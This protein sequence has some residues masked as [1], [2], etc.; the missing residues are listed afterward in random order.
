LLLPTR[1][2]PL[3]LLVLYRSAGFGDFLETVAGAS[4]AHSALLQFK[5]KTARYLIFGS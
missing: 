1:Q 4:D 5:S 3:R 2:T